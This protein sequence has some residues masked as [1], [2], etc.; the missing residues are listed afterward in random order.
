MNDIANNK[1]A[2][3]VYCFI[4]PREICWYGT[5]YMYNIKVIVSR[6]QEIPH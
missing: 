6:T 5:Q 1:F 4:V 2:T 3:T